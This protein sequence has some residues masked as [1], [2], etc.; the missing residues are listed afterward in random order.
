MVTQK[1]LQTSAERQK[2]YRERKKR[3][4]FFVSSYQYKRLVRLSAN[5]SNKDEL[6]AAIGDCYDAGGVELASRICSLVN[7]HLS[8][9]L[10]LRDSLAGV[11]E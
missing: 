3:E 11:W 8:I 6:L 9:R 10:S 7:E 2:A 5:L 4:H 1:T